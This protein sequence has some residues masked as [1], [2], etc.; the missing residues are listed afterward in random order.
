VLV[1]A[2]IAVARRS[3][4][5]VGVQIAVVIGGGVV[6]LLTYRLFGDGGRFPFGV[7]QLV[8]ALIFCGLG[9]VVTGGVPAAR[10]LRGLF[11]IYLA[12]V[13]LT[14]AVPSSIGSNIERIRYAALPIALIAVG[15]RR[16]RPLWLAVPA[17]V[18]AAVWNLTPILSSFAQA[19]SDPEAAYSYWQP[20]L[21]YLKAHSSPSFR[22]EVVDTA[23]HWQAAYLPDA[24]IPIVRGWYRQNDFPQNELLYDNT[25]VRRTYQAWLRR[26]AVRY[27][28]L[29]DAPVD[30]SARQ[31]AELIR[32]GTS[33]LMLVKLLPHMAIYELRN[34]A[35]LVTGPAPASV[36]W[37]WP[38][39]LVAE[40]GAPGTYDVRVRW[41]PY[42]RASAGC[43][44]KG[45]DGMTRVSV[46]RAGLVQLSFSLDVTRGLQT[47]AG[48]MPKRE[49]SP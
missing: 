42:W 21:A 17:L 45:A 14:Y 36:L 35:P 8:P 34:A 19:R 41:S 20:A 44:A 6:E 26:M 46:R 3:L 10:P 40:V 4:R 7:L 12:V 2:G 49:C 24:G 38:S 13:I 29:T 18:L 22:V 28:V 25:L 30:Y 1:L 27:I 47:L 23:E 31:E 15:L 11:L 16:Y 33:G 43:V 5:H 9:L 37:L 32:S 39:R 48:T